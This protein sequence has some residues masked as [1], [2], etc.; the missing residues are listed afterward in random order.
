MDTWDRVFVLRSEFAAQAEALAPTDWDAPSLCEGWRI[1][2]V[3]AHLI[4][5]EHFSGLGGLGGLIRSGFRLDRYIHQD[6]IRRG[7]VPVADLMASYRAG[8]PRR[9][10]P[11]GR[12]PVNVLVDL[13]VHL[14]DIRRA[15]GLP[16]SYDAELLE[17]VAST[18]YADTG[19]GVPKRAEGLALKATDTAWKAGEGALVAGPLEALILAMTGRP[20]TLPELTGPGAAV[21]AAR[22]GRRSPSLPG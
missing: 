18:I 1:R 3:V 14:Q 21:L 22:I 19:L 5:P 8:I 7:S 13:V 20:V 9:S 17:T 15:L 10:V 2:D 11:P 6:A 4:L 12:R 16:W